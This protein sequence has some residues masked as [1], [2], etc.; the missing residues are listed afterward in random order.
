MTALAKLTQWYSKQC[1]GD[2]EHSYGF[3]IDTLDNPGISLRVDLRETY[4]EAVPFTKKTEHRESEDRWMFCERTAE[5][6]VGRGA[7][8]RMED[9][10]EE[11]IRWARE[12][13]SA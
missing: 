5:A 8:S 4:L 10:I 11:F 12:N 7:P 6:F 3:T 2:W 9:I 13:E 1:N